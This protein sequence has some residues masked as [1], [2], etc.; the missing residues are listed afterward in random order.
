MRERF[1]RFS[2]DATLVRAILHS[3]D[4]VR[5]RKADDAPG[6]TALERCVREAA[7]ELPARDRRRV[8]AVLRVLDSAPTWELLTELCGLDATEA[9]ASV[10]LAT[11]ALVAGLTRSAQSEA[12]ACGS[13]ENDR[14]SENCELTLPPRGAAAPA[15]RD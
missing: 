14:D 4:G 12:I 2:A 15:H 1:A 5:L 10:E 8:A 11:E 3:P 7:P 9:A 13:D 6:N